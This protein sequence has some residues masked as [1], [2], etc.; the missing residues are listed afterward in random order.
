MVNSIYF[1]L[2]LAEK[3]G[4]AD[5]T[6]LINIFYNFNYPPAHVRTNFITKGFIYKKKIKPNEAIEIIK[7]KTCQQFE[8]HDTRICTWCHGET[9]SLERHHY[10][11]ERRH[12]GVDTVDICANCHREFHNLVNHGRIEIVAWIKEYFTPAL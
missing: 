7:T 6:I 5:T 3:I 1:P 8:F 11:K 10:P 4:I 2:D 9:L 12:G